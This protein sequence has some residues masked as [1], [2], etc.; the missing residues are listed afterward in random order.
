EEKHRESWKRDRPGV[1][2]YRLSELGVCKVLSE[3]LATPLLTASTSFCIMRRSDRGVVV[4][5]VKA[6]LDPG[7]RRSSLRS[8]PPIRRHRSSPMRSGIAVVA[9]PCLDEKS[10]SGRSGIRGQAEL[11]A[12]LSQR[13][14]WV[15]SDHQR[16]AHG[17][18]QRGV[19]P[20]LFP[21]APQGRMTNAL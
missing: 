1:T 15:E 11:N 9:L 19:R 16:Q 18:R 2:A 8:F 14:S 10:L 6:R 20:A 21:S 3:G 17:S 4:Q 13:R 5:L 7:P 12:G